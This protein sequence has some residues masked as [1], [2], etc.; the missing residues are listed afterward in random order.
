MFLRVYKKLSCR[1]EAARCFV[2]LNISLSHD[3]EIWVR[4]RS[5]P[6]EIDRYEF[7]SAFHS[8]YEPTLYYFRD[9]ARH[10]S[11]IVIILYP[12]HSTSL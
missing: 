8:N 5:K 11:K 6:L 4:G 12:L 7:L 3:L 9:I 10:E 2:S 1:R